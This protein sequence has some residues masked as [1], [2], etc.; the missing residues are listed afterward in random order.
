MLDPPITATPDDE[1][2]TICEIAAAC[3]QHEPLKR[4]RMR[5]VRSPSTA[6]FGQCMVDA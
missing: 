2:A 1:I 3:C 6:P 5:E 4:P